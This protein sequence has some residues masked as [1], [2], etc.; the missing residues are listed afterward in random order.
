MSGCAVERRG[1]YDPLAAEDTQQPHQ[2][3][4]GVTMLDADVR[5]ALLLVNHSAGKSPAGQI[6][7]RLTMQNALT[8]GEDLWADV[9]FVFYNEWNQPVETSQWQT[10]QFPPQ[11]LVL[12]ENNSIRNDVEKFNVQ[13]KDLKSRS[14]K[15]LTY[16]GKIYEHGYW[17]DTV[18]PK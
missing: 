13:F 10:I 1:P 14:G 12:V 15:K 4:S 11:E 8:A 18:S 16:P 17:K 5:N 9:R 6:Q 2:L 3:H 7:A